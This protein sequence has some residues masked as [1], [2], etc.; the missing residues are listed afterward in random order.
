[1]QINW[2]PEFD[3]DTKI[4]VDKISQWIEDAIFEKKLISGDR[5]PSQRRLAYY[6]GVNPTT[7]KRAYQRVMDKRLVA[8]EIGRG[9]YVLPESSAGLFARNIEVANKSID[10]VIDLSVNRLHVD[11]TLLAINKKITDENIY[12]YRAEQHEYISDVLLESFSIQVCNYLA[13]FRQIDFSKNA[14]L[15]V[16]SCFYGIRFILDNIATKGMAVLTEEYT[17]PNII[18][19]IQTL[20]LKPILCR[21]DN[22]GICA[23]DLA[24]KIK[25]SKARIL[26][27]VTTFQSPLGVTQSNSRRKTLAK[28]IKQHQLTLIE[29]DVYGI[30]SDKTPLLHF[31]PEQS[32]L[33]SGFSKIL[34]GGYRAAFIASQHPL[35]PNLQKLIQETSWLVSAQAVSHFITAI[36]R[37]EIGKA[38]DYQRQ[39]LLAKNKLLH[40]ALPDTYQS[41]ETRP[42]WWISLTNEQ[43]ASIQSAGYQLAESNYFSF[44][45]ASHSATDCDFYRISLL[46]CELDNFKVFS[47]HLAELYSDK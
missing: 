14:L 15:T 31:C 20:G 29:D 8:G 25:Q 23:D 22:E 46:D 28:L 33:V 9:T 10:K 37:G 27:S 38:I 3:A 45:P 47:E 32:F 18:N 34:T 5:L 43:Y 16:P 36:E 44:S 12:T 6:L 39:Q 7:V 17:S 19:A 21:C 40:T 2:I 41:L 13:K 26:V 30:Y 24:A 1:M 35:M 11:K 4:G 42:H